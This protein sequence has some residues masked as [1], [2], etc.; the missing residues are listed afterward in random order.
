MLSESAK[1]EQEKPMTASKTADNPKHPR[2]GWNAKFEE[3]AGNGD[4]AL[5]DQSVATTWDEEEWEW[6]LCVNDKPAPAYFD[7]I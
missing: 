7:A 6:E 2:E 3:M 5:L 4:D 1:M